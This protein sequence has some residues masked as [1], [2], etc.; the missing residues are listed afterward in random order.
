MESRTD[1]VRV[2]GA[3]LSQS[4]ESMLQ[5]NEL[6]ALRRMVADAG[7]NYQLSTCRIVLGEDQVI[8]DAEPGKINVRTLPV[9]WSA[10]VAVEP[11]A[12]EHS[13]ALSY[14]LRV[15]GRGGA[16][17]ELAATLVDR[18]WLFWEAQTGTAMIGAVA[19]ATL[20]LVYRQLRSRLVAVGAI[21]EALLAIG[22]GETSTETL[23]VDQGLGVEATAWNRLLT[24]QDKLKKKAVA[25]RTIERLEARRGIKSDSDAA[26]DAIPQGLVLV[27]AD[28][29]VKAA[30]GAA[31][32]LLKRRREELPGSQIRETLKDEK[33]LEPIRSIANGE[34]QRP[35]IVEVERQ[36][37]SG[38][39]VLRFS[40]RPVRK[41]DTAS[42]MLVIEDITQQRIAE[43]ARNSFIAQVT[44]ELRTPLTNI[45]L[46]VE[47]A[48]EDGETNPAVR[49]NCLNVIN[50]ESRRLERIVSEM[51]SVAEIEAGSFK[52]KKDDVYI[53]VMLDELKTD[54]TAQATE[55]TISLEFKRSPKLPKLQGDRDKIALALHNLIGNA[56]KY[57][58]SGGK[59]T[60]VTDTRDG[61]LM[62]DVI[63]TGIGIKPDEAERIFEKFYRSPDPRVGKI[64]GTGLGL[65]LA[66]EVVRLHG[67]DITL[68]SQLN[69]GS[70]FTA[71]FPI[72]A[73]AAH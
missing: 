6:S 55:K 21:R 73:E 48:I 56:L 51:L 2:V 32:V 39:G 63:D 69:H 34:T 64:T 71:V 72:P 16:R 62:V 47:T 1:Q 11:Q 57:T 33:V 8:A 26:W 60:V 17:L 37:D 38:V 15:S 68:Q 23:C 43:Q 40:V 27:N 36:G 67:G 30:N 20:L 12:D 41:E 66:R 29:T 58:P 14:P 31:A 22:M 5:A 61:Q 70:K 9:S 24:D 28:M 44:H 45:R 49:S 3:L 7:R 50:L 10:G 19:L 52:V 18:R 65:T 53:D 4:A 35:V 46:Y 25:E 13:I 42:A 59:V 54:Y